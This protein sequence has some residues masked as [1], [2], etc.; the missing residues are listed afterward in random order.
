MK[1]HDEAGAENAGENESN[2]GSSKLENPT[3]G[4]R[5]ALAAGWLGSA[6][7]ATCSIP[8]FITVMTQGHAEGLSLAFLLM[9]A[10]GEV[11]GLWFVV[12]IKITRSA[13]MPLLLNY[14]LNAIL[15]LAMLAVKLGG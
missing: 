8:Q 13:K 3:I 12:S 10:G 7:L 2:G 11:L 4:S 5:S 14:G 6:L 1:R 15:T 9:W